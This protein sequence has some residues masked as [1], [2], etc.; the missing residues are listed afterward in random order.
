MEK[1][2]EWKAS[3]EHE[4]MRVDRLLALL[5]PEISRSKI[6]QMIL[7]KKVLINEKPVKAKSRVR[8]GDMIQ[9]VIPPPEEEEIRPEK[10]PL[11]VVFE[12]R[13][14]LVINKAQGMV[15][16][17]APGNRKGT[18][19]NALLYYCP[20]LSN[21]GDS[22]RP[23]IV[24]RLDKDTSGLLVV[25]KNNSS[26]LALAAQIKERTFRRIYLTVVHGVVQEP[27]GLIEAPIGRHP[28][29]RKRMAVVDKNGK[30][31][32]T[33]YYVKER[34][35]EF[36]LLEVHLETGRT[37]QIRVHLAFL[38]HPVLG[39]GL[40][41]PAKNFLGLKKQLLHSY[42][43]GFTHPRTGRYME[44]TASLPGYFKEILARLAQA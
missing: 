38:K 15:V 10:I 25:A 16:H 34:Y 19:V 32:L 33:R 29:D 31:A 23:G 27:A 44:F 7:E 4:G 28:V 14:L 35:K 21:M 3:G 20:E 1:L 41:G 17:P 39:D 2:K 6:Q 9:M 37:H 13:D 30:P 40:Y 42:Q 36:T 11:G 43:L 18:L 5:V 24:H 8:E 22:S 26:H 12:D